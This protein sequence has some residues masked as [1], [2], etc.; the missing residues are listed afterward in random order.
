MQTSLRSSNQF[1]GVWFVHTALANQSCGWYSLRNRTGN[2]RWEKF[3]FL[4]NSTSSGN[5]DEICLSW[6]KVLRIGIRFPLV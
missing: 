6:C 1:I 5:F 3:N 4:V 2:Q